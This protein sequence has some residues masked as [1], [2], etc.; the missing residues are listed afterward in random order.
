VNEDI[1]VPN[2]RLID[3]DGEQV[4]IVPLE[5][6]MAK[7]NEAE[8][9]LVEVAPNA[10]PPV[11]RIMNFGKFKYEQQKREHAQRKKSHQ[12][13]LKEL[14]LGRST[15]VEEHDLDFKCKKARE[16]LSKGHRLQVYLQ[17][18][19]R[20]LAHA[21]VGAETLAHFAENLS[22]VAKVENRPRQDRRRVTMLLAPLPNAGKPGGKKD[23]DADAPQA[24]AAGEAGGEEG[25]A[26]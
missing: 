13:E 16:I 18:R 19:G 11:C 22:D 25:D 1:R 15:K 8:L 20:E 26:S 7:A 21:E 10:E 4:G 24:E 3:E 6:A 17:L 2:V 5:E 23:E 14:R 9:D 12:T